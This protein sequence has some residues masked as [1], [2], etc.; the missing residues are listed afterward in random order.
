MHDFLAG[1]IDGLACLRMG[2]GDRRAGG[3]FEGAE[4]SEPELP[5]IDDVIGND[6]EKFLQD[7]AS[8]P[9]GKGEL[10]GYDVGDGVLCVG[11]RR[12]FLRRQ[13]KSSL[14]EAVVARACT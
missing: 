1:Y 3:D 4:A 11:H 2:D 10:L 12:V 7:L 8:G 5:G 6:V 13:G 14:W 9:H